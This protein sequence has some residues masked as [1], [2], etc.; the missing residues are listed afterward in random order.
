MTDCCL[1]LQGRRT[2]IFPLK[3]QAIISYRNYCALKM[4]MLCVF[5]TSINATG[6]HGAT[7]QGSIFFLVRIRSRRCLQT[8]QRQWCLTNHKRKSQFFHSLSYEMWRS[9][10]L[11][12]LLLC[13]ILNFLCSFSTSVSWRDFQSFCIYKTKF[14]QKKILYKTRT[15][16]SQLLYLLKS[17][18]TAI[19]SVVDR[20]VR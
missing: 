20:T 12:W 13:E 3:M 4:G 1:H 17:V 11:H 7:P 9:W 15:W 6:L 14:Q 16:R 5:E 18:C 8:E 2:R 19:S 10:F